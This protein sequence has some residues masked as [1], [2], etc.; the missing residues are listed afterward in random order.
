MVL[1]EKDVEL[2]ASEKDVWQL[3]VAWGA[4]VRSDDFI[5]RPS[6]DDVLNGAIDEDF[7]R[8]RSLELE[9]IIDQIDALI[10]STCI[11]Q[12]DRYQKTLD[13]AL[14]ESYRQLGKLLFSAVK[15]Q[16]E[17]APEQ[18]YNRRVDSRRRSKKEKADEL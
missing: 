4:G 3:V 5:E 1:C 7:W 13:E 6:L 12:E 16:R 2:L 11:K 18:I 10:T 8:M 14:D 17:D 15:R 9:W